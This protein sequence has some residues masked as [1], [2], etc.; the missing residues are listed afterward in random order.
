MQ[1]LVAVKEVTR[2]TDEFEFDGNQI[3]DKFIEYGLNEWDEYAVEEAVRLREDGPADEVVSVTIGPERS[4][5]TIRMALSKGVDRSIRFWDEELESQQILDVKTRTDIL[6]SIV[7]EVSPDLILT[8]VQAGD[9][10]FASTGVMLA[11]RIGWGWGAVVT[12]L[13]LEDDTARVKREL[14]GG[15]EELVDITLPAVFTIQTGINTPRYASLRG[16]REAQDKE[17]RTFDLADVD[18]SPS[19]IQSE[20]TLTEMYEPEAEGTTQYIEGEPDEEATQLVDILADEE[21]VVR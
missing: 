7:S 9:D 11:N 14:E 3:Q 16:I 8:G 17:I 18:L 10:G 15:M 21:V 20:L 1:V 4:E 12:D 19:A 5:E 6:E 2:V 13:T